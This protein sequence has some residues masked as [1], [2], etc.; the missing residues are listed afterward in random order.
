MASFL[1]LLEMQWWNSLVAQWLRIWHCHC[2]VGLISGLGTS[3]CC[4]QGQ[5][6]KKK[7]KGKKEMQWILGSQSW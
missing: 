6:K 5:K 2:A 4:G 3:V 7:K 1:K